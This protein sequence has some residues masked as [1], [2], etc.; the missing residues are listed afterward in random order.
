MRKHLHTGKI[1]L[2]VAVVLIVFTLYLRLFAGEVLECATSQNGY[3]AEWRI[4]W[5]HSATTPNTYAVQLRS[6]FNPFRH[7]VL[8]GEFAVSPSLKW[9]DSHNLFVEC[10]GC[11]N[12]EVDCDSCQEFHVDVKET[13]WHDVTIH[14]DK[15]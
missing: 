3:V 9:I 10:D 7:T 12:F 14:Y 6:R 11:G 13:K 8:A 1:I 2:G 15:R 5:T 4:Y